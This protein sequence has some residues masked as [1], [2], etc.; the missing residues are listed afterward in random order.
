M[1]RTRYRP[2][3]LERIFGE[4]EDADA[5]AAIAVGGS[6][7]EHALETTILCRLR[8]P[9]T[10][11][12]R[13]V[14]FHDSGIIRTFSEK[15]WLAFFLRVIGPLTRRDVDLIRLIR[16]QAA[17]DMN[18]ISFE[19]TPEIKSRCMELR[20]GLEFYSRQPLSPRECF[21]LVAQTITVNLW[22][23]SGDKSARIQPAFEGLA[24][25]L[26]A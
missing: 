26:D 7:V 24:S 19:E 21:L 17:H 16:N 10:D 11:P 23:R 14:F 18:P 6:L 8:E 13:D 12:E 25:M 15:I 2:K 9:T 22:M 20:F 1:A 4:L 3:D 5:R